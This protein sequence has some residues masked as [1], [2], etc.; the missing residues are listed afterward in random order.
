M[1]GVGQELKETK[2]QKY[3][4]L[5][6]GT[7]NCR[8][9]IA[10]PEGAGFRVVDAFSRIVRLGEGLEASGRLSDAA[11]ARSID[12]L[13]ICAAKMRA[14]GIVASR[15]VATEA[16]R[17]ASNCDPFIR[18]VANETGLQLEIISA[19]EEARLASAGCVPLLDLATDR[20]LIFD[21]GG[22]STELTFLGLT[23]GGRAEVLDM[24]SLP[25]GVVTVSERHGCA[26]S[27]E[28]YQGVMAEIR[29]LLEPF[30][31]N[32][33]IASLIAASA[34]QM[35]GTSGTVTTL[36]AVHLDLPRYDR[37]RID[38]TYLGRDQIGAVSQRLAAMDPTMRAAHP[39][40]GRDRAD[41]VVSGCAILE[42]ILSLWPV[43]RLRVA[44]RGVRD[45]IL[46][47]LMDKA[48]AA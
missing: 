6:L 8:L 41:L 16:C 32:H 12:A 47:G 4:A 7:H 34:V 42:A 30:E 24:V 20:A 44:D 27:P 23:S 3:A 1:L 13:R 10:V 31:K 28:G 22:G 14:G 39:C 43:H 2:V 9:L 19:A 26:L 29:A 17:R 21:I 5:D 46:L 36:A 33:R 25:H 48:D 18:R 35:L 40:I 11:M 38:A 45:G 15:L 37:A